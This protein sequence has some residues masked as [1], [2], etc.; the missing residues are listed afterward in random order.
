MTTTNDNITGYKVTY[1][2]T[3]A[4]ERFDSYEAAEAAVRSVFADPSIGHDGDIAS[5]GERTLVWADEASGVNDD[6]ARA[7]ASIWA[8]HADEVRS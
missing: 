8:Q 1:A 5:G 2:H 3:S 6:G 7:V 4:V